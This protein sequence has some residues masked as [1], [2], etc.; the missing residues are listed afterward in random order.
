MG[1]ALCHAHQP[2]AIHSN[3][4]VFPSERQMPG[5]QFLSQHNSKATNIY[6]ALVGQGIL[7]VL[8]GGLCSLQEL[9]ELGEG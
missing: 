9:T 3:Q 6:T 4:M 7:P 1:A 5:D 8:R 2:Q